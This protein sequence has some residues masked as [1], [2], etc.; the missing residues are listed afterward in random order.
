VP[1]CGDTTITEVVRSGGSS[2]TRGKVGEVEKYYTGY[3]SEGGMNNY[4]AFNN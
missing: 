2:T 4:I 3:Y 1:A